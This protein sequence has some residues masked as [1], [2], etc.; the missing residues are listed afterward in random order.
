MDLI[1]KAPGLNH[2]LETILAHLDNENIVKFGKVNKESGEIVEG[3]TKSPWFWFKKCRKNGGIPQQHHENSTEV[4][5][6][7]GKPSQPQN[8][9]KN[10][11]S[12][13]LSNKGPQETF[14]IQKC[15]EFRWEQLWF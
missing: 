7:L 4:M 11:K 5:K 3:I 10:Q 8:L 2:I 12:G 9:T 15:A 13:K 6:I 14:F 1:I